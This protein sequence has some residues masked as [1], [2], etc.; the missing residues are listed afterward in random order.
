MSGAALSLLDQGARNFVL[1]LARPRTEL[2]TRETHRQPTGDETTIVARE[3]QPI[4]A[5]DE[6]GRIMLAPGGR[7]LAEDI[8]GSGSLQIV[9]NESQPAEIVIADRALSLW[10]ERIQLSHLRFTRQSNATDLSSPLLIADCQN[11]EAQHV[12]FD[13]PGD[14]STQTRRRGAALAWR[15]QESRS[16]RETQVALRDVVFAGAASG[17]LSGF[18]AEPVRRRQRAEGRSRRLHPTERPRSRHLDLRPATSHAR[19]SGPLLRCWTTPETSPLSRLTLSATG[20]V[21]DLE[22]P[23]NHTTSETTRPSLIAW[24]TGRLPSNWT[25]AID[26]QLTGTL[27]STDVDVITRIDPSTGRRTPVD[28]SRLHIDGLVAARFDFA[29][30]ESPHPADSSLQSSDAPRANTSPI[31]IDADKLLPASSN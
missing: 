20:C 15:P 21:F 26:W 28:E 25:T 17:D 16:R 6:S 4:P 8:A 1:S 29:G 27:V 11:F 5:P 2:L 31:G 23:T 22:R 10:A 19:G 7:Y 9:G 3:P 30:P 18:A 14:N 12:R 24:M 13:Q